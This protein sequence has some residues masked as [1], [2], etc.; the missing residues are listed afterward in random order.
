MLSLNAPLGGA[1]GLVPPGPPPP[2]GAT[3]LGVAVPCCEAGCPQPVATDRQAAKTATDNVSS[4]HF[5]LLTP[6]RCEYT[7]FFISMYRVM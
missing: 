4:L 1:V 2:S 5:M 3:V 6:F 7:G